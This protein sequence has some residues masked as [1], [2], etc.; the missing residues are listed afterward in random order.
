MQGTVF[1]FN[2]LLIKKI[3][4]GLHKY[5]FKAKVRNIKFYALIM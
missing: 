5:L 2:L 3:F 4:L 1:N